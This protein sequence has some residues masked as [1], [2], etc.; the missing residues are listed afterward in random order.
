M[1]IGLLWLLNIKV[2]QYFSLHGGIPSYI[3]IAALITLMNILFH[4]ILRIVFAPFHFFFGFIA[5]IL[6]NAVFLWFIVNI[7][8]QLDPNIV[9]FTIQ[10]GIWNWFVA[11]TVFGIGN[12]LVKF[13]VK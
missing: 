6:M 13:L 12:W 1:T 3:I 8:Q 7:A 5:T 10:G 2:D 4:P 11:S 9:T